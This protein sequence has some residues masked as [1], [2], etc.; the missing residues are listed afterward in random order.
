MAAPG[1][2]SETLGKCN[3]L[4]QFSTFPFESDDGY[5]VLTI[6]RSYFVCRSNVLNMQAR[7]FE[8]IGKRNLERKI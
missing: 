4:Q 8:H 5:K 7:S 2:E 1:N 3:A 6:V